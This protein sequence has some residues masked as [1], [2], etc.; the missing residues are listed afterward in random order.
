MREKKKPYKGKPGPADFMD[1][2]CQTFKKELALTFLKLF[3]K[4][5][6]HFITH[7]MRLILP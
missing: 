1:E 4:I 5:K 6:E 7:F 2:C 3:G